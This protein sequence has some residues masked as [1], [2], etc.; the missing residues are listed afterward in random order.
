MFKAWKLLQ[1]HCGPMHSTDN[2]GVK[3]EK[4]R[5]T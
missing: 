1:F 5:C 4:N 2:D 3:R